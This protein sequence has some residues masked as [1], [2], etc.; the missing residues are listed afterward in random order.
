MSLLFTFTLFGAGISSDLT[1]NISI[2]VINSYHDLH[3]K[4]IG[5]ISGSTAE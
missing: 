4:N 1:L 5:V 3:N 2:N